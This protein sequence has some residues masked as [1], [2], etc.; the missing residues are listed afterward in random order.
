MIFWH[1]S[2]CLTAIAFFHIFSNVFVELGHRDLFFKAGILHRDISSGNL[3]VRP[4]FCCNEEDGTFYVEWV[5][6][7]TDWEVSKPIAKGKVKEHS[8]HHLPGSCC[9]G[10]P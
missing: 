3:L 9:I 4:V 10:G 8:S 2:I 5:G 6:L 1:V 7:L